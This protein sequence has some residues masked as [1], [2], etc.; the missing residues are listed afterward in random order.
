M[1]P[2][3]TFFFIQIEPFFGNMTNIDIHYENVSMHM[4]EMIQSV[5]AMQN[6][7]GPIMPEIVQSYNTSVIS[8][9]SKS[10]DYMKQ[11]AELPISQ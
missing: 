7:T 5:M 2:P 8:I 11:L 4:M 1:Y 10:Q 3:S 9:M 6:F